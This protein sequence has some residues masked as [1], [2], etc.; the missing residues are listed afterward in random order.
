VAP[1]IV[2]APMMRG[3][4]VLSAE[5]VAG[6]TS[7]SSTESTTTT[8]STSGSSFPS[9][10]VK[11]DVEVSTTGVN[12]LWN[13]GASNVFAIP[14]LAIDA[15]VGPQVTLGGSAGFLSR[16]GSTKTS[17]VTTSGSSTSRSTSSND[18]LPDVSA[19]VVSPRLGVVIALGPKAALWLRGGVTY[20][21]ASVESTTVSPPLSSG[22]PTITTKRT[23]ETSGTAATF[24]AQLVLMP[25]DHVGIT[26]G[27]VF[28]IGLGG[29]TKT[30]TT[31]T[32]SD[33][34][35]SQTINREGD[36]TESNYGAAAGILAFF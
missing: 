36:L 31:T 26:I 13:G 9:N 19:F 6:V 23:A 12:L 25:I 32:S 1:A 5:R 14:R 18:D 33:S 21:S 28:D 29:S 3:H 17:T 27:P 10:T 11:E 7:M 34:T 35:A 4:V 30:T 20:Y 15:F 2:A 16:G 24:D 8:F 22:D